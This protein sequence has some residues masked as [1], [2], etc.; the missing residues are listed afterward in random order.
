MECLIC[1]KE[2][3]DGDRYEF[4]KPSTGELV[5]VV[6]QDC[7]DESERLFDEEFAGKE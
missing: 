2:V 5:M 4:T 3:A 6:C 1:K 7:T